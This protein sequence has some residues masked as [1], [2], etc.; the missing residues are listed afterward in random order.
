MSSFIVT[1]DG[2]P[3]ATVDL[4]KDRSW[5]GGR[6]TPLAAF[7]RLAPLLAAAAGAPTFAAKLLELPSGDALATDGLPPRVAAAYQSLAAC[8]FDLL[9]EAG[10]PAGAELVRLAP[11]GAGTTAVVRAYFRNAPSRA[12]ARLPVSPR[13]EGGAAKAPGA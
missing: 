2:A 7:E 8:S 10:L 12:A 6:V 1:L 9:D 4:P 3:L 13:V 11:I 5:A